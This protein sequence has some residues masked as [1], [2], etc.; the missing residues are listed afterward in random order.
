MSLQ[1]EVRE[2]TRGIARAWDVLPV[3]DV[4][5]LEEEPL[6]TV[7]LPAVVGGV[8]VVP[9]PETVARAKRK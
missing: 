1:W 3:T 8:L 2:I 9:P 5:R 6:L 4:E 7:V